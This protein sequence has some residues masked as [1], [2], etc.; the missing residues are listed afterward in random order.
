M[1][2]RRLLPFELTYSLKD[3]VMS[4]A[5]RNVVPISEA[6]ARLTELTDDV[7]S[8]TEKLLTKNGAV[9]SVFYEL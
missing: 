9:D 1:F 8:G 2:D 3:V 6:R 7:V 4:V 5:A